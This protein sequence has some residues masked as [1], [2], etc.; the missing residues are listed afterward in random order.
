[1]PALP[2]TMSKPPNQAIFL[3]KNA[4]RRESDVELQTESRFS[5]NS[6][7]DARR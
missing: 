7:L 4:K 2:R 5:G 6:P 3:R 1:V